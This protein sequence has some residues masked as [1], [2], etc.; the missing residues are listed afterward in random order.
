MNPQT[1]Q[2]QPFFGRKISKIGVNVTQATDNQLILKEDYDQG[3]TIYYDDSGIP[4]VL[5][6]KRPL[7]G[8]RGF[9]V[10]KPGIDVTRASDDELI[11]NSQ[12]DAFKIVNAGT[13]TINVPNSSNDFLAQVVVNH[14]LGYVPAYLAYIVPPAG[15][16]SYVNE[17]QLP[18]FSYILFDSST[19]ISAGWHINGK[20]DVGSLTSTSITFTLSFVFNSSNNVGDWTFRYYLLQ[21][22]AN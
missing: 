11:F 13:A 15:Y 10:A 16:S 12:E 5:I 14:D 19:G 4:N 20:A 17:S 18:F 1:P 8:I 22:T 9:Y 3:N 6:G 2:Q 7:T 21:E